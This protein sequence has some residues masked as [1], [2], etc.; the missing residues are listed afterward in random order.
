[1]DSISE[2]N[3][4]LTLSSMM[5]NILTFSQTPPLFLGLASNSAS[6]SS[7]YSRQSLKSL[8]TQY[9]I[10]D[11]PDVNTKDCDRILDSI[12]GASTGTSSAV[13]EL[14][15]VTSVLAAFFLLFHSDNFL[16][17][18]DSDC[19]KRNFTK[20]PDN[21]DI[22]S[23]PSCSTPRTFKT[24][25]AMFIRSLSQPTRT[26][27]CASL[28]RSDCMM[29]DNEALQLVWK[30]GNIWLQPVPAS[31][32][33]TKKGGANALRDPEKDSISFLADTDNQG[34]VKYWKKEWNWT[35]DI[36]FVPAT[37]RMRTCGYDVSESSAA[38]KQKLALPKS[39]PSPRSL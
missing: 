8:P 17:H 21:E 37:S 31:F 1:M 30:I 3:S 7:S 25:N 24:S 39:P 38:K 29:K 10:K 26:S 28:I 12:V 5:M 36:F 20:H 14:S 9:T 18:S 2:Y 16:Y 23:I 35:E 15:R 4:A 11:P 33:D 19:D 34:K 13:R 6:L 32:K 22:L 27:I